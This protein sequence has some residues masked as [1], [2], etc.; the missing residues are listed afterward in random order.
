MDCFYLQFAVEIEVRAELRIKLDPGQELCDLQRQAANSIG[1]P[2]WR[3]VIHEG[4]FVVTSPSAFY[5]HE[6]KS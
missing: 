2:E 1:V 6:G 5:R 4:P 3:F